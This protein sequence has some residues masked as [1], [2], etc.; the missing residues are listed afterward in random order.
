MNSASQPDTP[1]EWSK[2]APLRPRQRSLSELEITQDPS[3]ASSSSESVTPDA[4]QEVG[5]A[6]PAPALPAEQAP[7]VLL[8]TPKTFPT[9]RFD[10][11]NRKCREKRE[12]RALSPRHLLSAHWRAMRIGKRASLV[13]DLSVQCPDCNL[14]HHYTLV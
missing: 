6:S 4:L 13:L 10:C 2:F 3:A 1:S 14:E 7:E 12:Q 8:L 5:S 11:Q 9:D